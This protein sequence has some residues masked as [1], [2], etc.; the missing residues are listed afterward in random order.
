M[1]VYALLA[2][3]IAIVGLGIIGTGYL[4]NAIL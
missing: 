3:F 1:F 2:L 4:F